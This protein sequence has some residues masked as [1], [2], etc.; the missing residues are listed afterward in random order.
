[1][2][3][4]NMKNALA[5]STTL[6]AIRLNVYEYI[7]PEITFADHSLNEIKGQ[8]YHSS[9]VDVHENAGRL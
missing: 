1:M 2:F 8:G 9:R 3:S 7:Q 5:F 6:Y 4:N